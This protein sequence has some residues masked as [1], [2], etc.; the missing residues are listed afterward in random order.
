MTETDEEIPT[1]KSFYIHDCPSLSG[2]STLTYVVG[3]DAAADTLHLAIVGNTGNGLWFKGWSLASEIEA[4]VANKQGLT[5]KSFCNL[6]P[7]RSVN[8]GGFILAALADLGLVQANPFNRNQY[9]HISKATFEQV[10]AVRMRIQEP[11]DARPRRKKAKEI[12]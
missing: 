10:V 4:L 11:E 8:T 3:K 5:A 1:I 12:L 7:G 2:K 9:E 6:H